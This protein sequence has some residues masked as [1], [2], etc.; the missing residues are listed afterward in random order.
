[1]WHD[2]KK[3]WK[4]F[5]ALALAAGLLFPTTVAQS[6]I[7]CTLPFTLTNGTI[8]DAT[9]VMSNY[10]ALVT[11][12]TLAASAG[13]NNDI[14]SLTG[15]TTPLGP[16][17]GG[18]GTFAGLTTT[19]SA[20]SQVL[21][22]VTPANF[23]LT[24]NYRVTLFAGFTNTAA[25]QLNVNGTGLKNVFRKTQLGV[26]LT[27]GGEFVALQP[28]T[29]VYDGTEY[30]IDGERRVVGEIRD[31]GGTTAPPGAVLASG[32]AISR[33]TFIDLFSV[34]GTAY[35]NGDGSTTFNV[36]DL[37]GRITAG[38]DN[39]GGSAANRITVAGGNFD[40]TVLGGSGGLQNHV[41]TVA[42]LAAH[43]HTITDPGHTHSYTLTNTNNIIL[44]A[45]GGSTANTGA[46]ASTTGS[47]ATG[48]TIN[49]NGSSSPMT[50]LQPTTITTKIIYF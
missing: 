7:T 2:M 19:G 31:F 32:Q 42:E 22:S 37:R 35:G 13:A 16:T 49:N 5:A 1:M 11:C 43:N 38:Q 50:I 27:V 18:S 10:N 29:L 23:T 8:A 14:T 33:T 48:I 34:L 15:L 4:K 28:V 24:T 45:S 12:F 30:I 9:Q 25:L 39:M 6:T 26:S 40:G 21:A 20:N 41:Q 36:P 3:L 46:S 44:T 17:F 47:S